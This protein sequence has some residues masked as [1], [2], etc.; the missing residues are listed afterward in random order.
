MSSHD[1]RSVGT[2]L[3]SNTGEFRAAPD[4]SASTAQFKAFAR[5]YD[6]QPEQPWAADSWPAQPPAGSSD[7]A[8]SRRTAVIVAV[9]LLIVVAVVVTVL[10]VG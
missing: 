3:P 5:S 1:D 8:G 10:V 6:S 9:A 4:I 7:V 2:G